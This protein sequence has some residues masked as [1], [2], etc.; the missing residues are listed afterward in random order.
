MKKYQAGGLAMAFGAEE[1]DENFVGPP[2]SLAGPASEEE[3][4]SQNLESMFFGSGLDIQD[5]LGQYQDTAKQSQ[6][7]LRQAREKVLAR[8][9]D[10]RQKWL[11][12]A[13]ALGAPTKTGAFGE[14]IGQVA[15][16]LGPEFARERQFNQ[17]KES[18]LLQLDQGVLGIDEKLLGQKLNVGLVFPKGRLKRLLRSQRGSGGY[19]N[20]LMSGLKRPQ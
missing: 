15:G 6:E 7:L 11:A 10:P 16:A 13:S 12:A 14:T 3:D 1:E 4:P 19:L 2:S 5:I 20:F 17:Q 9:Y 18:D 8:E